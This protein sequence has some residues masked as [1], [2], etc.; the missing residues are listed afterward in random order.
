MKPGN[1]ESQGGRHAQAD[2]C[3][4]ESVSVEIPP[5]PDELPAVFEAVEDFGESVGWSMPFVMQAQLV[6]EEMMLNVMTHSG[7][8]EPVKMRLTSRGSE[9]EFE[10]VDNG[11]PFDPTIASAPPEHDASSLMDMAVGG[12]GIHLVRSMVQDMRYQRENDSNR[13]TLLL[14]SSDT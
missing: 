11:K 1:K 14:V 2:N 8:T 7:A 12:L 4:Q 10:I 5:D 6:L 9:A 13:L 3:C